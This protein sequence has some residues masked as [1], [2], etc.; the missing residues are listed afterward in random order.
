MFIFLYI[1]KFELRLR[2]L[3]GMR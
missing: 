2:C 1:T 3:Q